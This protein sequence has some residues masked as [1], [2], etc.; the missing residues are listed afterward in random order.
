MARKNDGLLWHLM[1]APWWVSVLFAA[2]AYMGL[3]F[4]LPML[5]MSSENF[6]FNSV[7]PNLPIL[8]PY[9]AFTLLIPAPVA[10]F[11]QLSRQRQ[12]STTTNEI[13]SQG[14][15]AAL[16]NLSWLEFEG[17]IG[18]FFKQQG[19]EV[20]QA[21]SQKPDGGVDIWMRKDGQLTLVQCKHWKARKV[22]IQILREMYAVMIEHNASKM[23]VVTSGD[24]TSEA[25]KYALDKR[26]WLING[27]E[28]VQMIEQ[29]C[30]RPTEKTLE[31]TPPKST[32]PLCPS[33]HTPL[34]MRTAKRGQ[35]KGNQ[36]YGCSS[37]PRCRYTKDISAA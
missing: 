35:N 17:Y 3:S 23:I 21:F 7:A 27:G 30:N 32:T 2:I 14:T 37:Y 36:F 11:K 1:D 12:Y 29:V 34:V 31:V 26:L 5:A 20:K 9:V 22:G 8:A 16:N 28:L 24:F 4:V 15:T 33:C 25:I 10:L 13:A 19:Y 18:E 6:I